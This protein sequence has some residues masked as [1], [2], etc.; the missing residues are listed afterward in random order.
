[1]ELFQSN[2]LDLP[3]DVQR[4][5][6]SR[7][8]DP[9][10]IS[11]TSRTNSYIKNILYTSIT[12]LDTP[13]DRNPNKIDDY[14]P[15]LLDIRW[16]ID[17]PFLEYVSDNIVFVLDTY[18]Y[19]PYT[20][21]V[22]ELSLPRNLRKFNIKIDVMDI[23]N[24]DSTTVIM[25]I[26]ELIRTMGN[27]LNEYMIRFIS[28]F[29]GTDSS[30]AIILEYGTVGYINNFS[31]PNMLFDT[32]EIEMNIDKMFELLDIKLLN[33]EYANDLYYYKNNPRG[34]YMIIKYID[35][36]IFR[37]IS[38]RTYYIDQIVNLYTSQY[39][40]L[41]SHMDVIIKRYKTTG[42]IDINT[43]IKLVEYSAYEIIKEKI[44]DENFKEKIRK[45]KN[46]RINQDGSRIIHIGDIIEFISSKL[47][48]IIHFSSSIF[49]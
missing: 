34:N 10:E 48:L 47:S 4:E 17:Y 21:N 30:N 37:H 46:T 13:L 12:H 41:L 26:L 24:Y 11:N 3:V 9:Y 15:V 1:M 40:H 27:N 36:S 29:D 44:Q 23:N 33:L 6:L 31:K 20:E 28:T 16:L 18:K 14:N 8:T 49:N 45:I 19:Y 7:V 42:Y 38:Y 32:F 39:S 43:I 2:I 25:K 5:V 22:L 35:K